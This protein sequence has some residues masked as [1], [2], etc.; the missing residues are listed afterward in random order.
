M[1]PLRG[2][3]DLGAMAMKSYFTFSKSPR[4]EPRHQIFWYIQDTH[5]WGLTLLQI[6]SRCVLQSRL[7]GLYIWYLSTC[8]SCRY[9]FNKYYIYISNIY[10]NLDPIYIYIY[11]HI[12]TVGLMI[13]RNNNTF[14]WTDKDRIIHK[15]KRWNC[16]FSALFFLHAFCL[17]EFNLLSLVVV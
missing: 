15:N 12:Y 2:R 10:L 1:L 8:V 14:T 6:R 17:S 4:L 11:I 16:R 3:V 7:S 5:W 13:N 9:R